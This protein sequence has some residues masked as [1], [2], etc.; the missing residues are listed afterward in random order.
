MA[1]NEALLTRRAHYMATTPTRYWQ[2]LL[3]GERFDTQSITISRQ[4]I[5][6]FAA[7]FDPQPY[8]LNAEAAEDSIFGG[9]CASG[10]HVTALMMRLLTDTFTSRHIDLLGSNGVSNLRWRK[11]VF[12]GDSLSSRITVVDCT[13]ASADS[14]FGY[15][16]CDVEVDNQSGEQVIALVTSLMIGID[17]GATHHG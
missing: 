1:D 9:L 12:A 7:E 3:P 13:A 2:D 16:N 6:E 15:I 5:L 11:P 14:P 8:H 10:W 17:G 4:D